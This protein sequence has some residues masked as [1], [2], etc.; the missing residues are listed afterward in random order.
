MLR[1]PPS[2]KTAESPAVYFASNPFDRCGMTVYVWKMEVAAG[3]PRDLQL[4]FAVLDT[5]IAIPLDRLKHS[6]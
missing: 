6:F 4:K 5:G 1:N 2:P 3:N